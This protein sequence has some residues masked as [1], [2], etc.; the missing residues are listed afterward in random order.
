ME[1]KDS[2]GVVLI[3]GDAV[4]LIQDLK[5]Q[6]SSQV[7]KRCEV[8]KNIKLVDGDTELIECKGIFLKTCFIKK[9]KDKKKK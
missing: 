9:R 5:L 7:F 4:E 6:G 3:D 8:F 2:N 1:T